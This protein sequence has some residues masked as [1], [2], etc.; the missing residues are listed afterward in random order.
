MQQVRV[1]QTR[2]IKTMT[3]TECELAHLEA[4]RLIEFL[5]GATRRCAMCDEE[6]MPRHVAQEFCSEECAIAYDR[7]VAML[8]ESL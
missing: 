4:E 6:F 5:S 8:I 1:H 2:R 3:R 7:Q